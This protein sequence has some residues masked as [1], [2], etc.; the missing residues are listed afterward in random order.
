MKRHRYFAFLFFFLCE[1]TWSKN[2]IVNE[3]IDIQTQLR[4]TNATYIIKSPLDL[5]GKTINLPQGCT[6]LFSNGSISNGMLNGHVKIKGNISKGCLNVRFSKESSIDSYLPIFNYSTDIVASQLHACRNGCYLAEDIY[7]G[8][9]VYLQTSIDGQKNTVTISENLNTGFYITD[10]KKP[11]TISNIV[12]TKQIKPNSINMNYVLYAINSSNITV[13]NST[14]NG[15]L[16]FVNKTKSDDEDK[17]SKNIKIINCELNCDLSKCPQGFEYLQDHLSFYSIKNISILNCKINSLNVNRVIKTSAYFS[18]N[19]YEEAVNCTDGVDFE[20]N[21]VFATSSHGKQL[22]DMF[23]GTVNVVVKGNY[24]SSHGFTKFIENKAYQ[25]KNKKLKP[26]QS[27]FLICNNV[28]ELE[29]SSIFQFRANAKNDSFIVRDNDFT[30][31]G[32]NLNTNTGSNRSCG[33]YLQGYRKCIIESN[34]FTYKDEAIGILFAKVNFDCVKT[35]IKNNKI[36]DAYRIYFG[37]ADHPVR[38]KE[39][40]SC[41]EFTYVDNIRYYTSSYYEQKNELFVSD[42]DIRF[43]NVHIDNVSDTSPVILHKGTKI[44]IFSISPKH[45]SPQ[46]IN[47]ASKDVRVDSMRMMSRINYY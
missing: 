14:I 44:G 29:N 9:S 17:I 11:V 4:A 38:G 21:E 2:I 25:P 40:T 28:V 47:K 10:F 36:T 33:I 13:E 8:K 15:R 26:I 1:I 6:I 20:N 35:V 24:F 19:K 34:S 12:I 23:C 16:F 22:W 31:Y 3:D 30:V 42:S 46:L 27:T 45:N 43:L 32:S 39:Q 18:E 37:K 41:A 7:I 5:K